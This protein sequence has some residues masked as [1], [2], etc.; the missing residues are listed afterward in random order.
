MEQ[1]PIVFRQTVNFLFLS[2]AR[3]QVLVGLQAASSVMGEYV[4]TNQDNGLTLTTLPHFRR[5]PGALM[6]LLTEMA[7]LPKD[8]PPTH[9]KCQRYTLVQQLIEAKAN[10]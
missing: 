4:S 5:P 8:P 10:L 3:P 7:L 2:R 6:Q 1:N 9:E